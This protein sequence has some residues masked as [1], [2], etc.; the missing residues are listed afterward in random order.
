MPPLLRH[1]ASLFRDPDRGSECLH[2]L[3]ESRGHLQVQVRNGNACL[4]LVAQPSPIGNAQKS[5][6]QERDRWFE[7][8]FLHRRVRA[9]PLE[10]PGRAIVFNRRTPAMAAGLLPV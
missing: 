1:R 6:S 2:R 9:D 5:L 3:H 4:E 7:F 8:G 10:G